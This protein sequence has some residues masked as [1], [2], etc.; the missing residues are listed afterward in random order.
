M[1]KDDG[2]HWSG[3][4]KEKATESAYKQSDD[5]QQGV[6]DM[7]KNLYNDGDDEMKQMIAK[8]WVSAFLCAHLLA[9]LQCHLMVQTETQSKKAG[10]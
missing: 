1:R 10:M 2:G 7:M 5:P 3:L 4:K 6:M 9:S 8:T